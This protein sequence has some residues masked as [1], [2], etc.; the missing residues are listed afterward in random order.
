MGNVIQLR[1]LIRMACLNL[2]M[3][4]LTLR[5][6]DACDSTEMIFCEYATIRIQCLIQNL[7]SCCKMRINEQQLRGNDAEKV[8]I[9]VNN[10]FNNTY[11]ARTPDLSHVYFD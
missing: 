7:I 10:T 1:V 2:K 9:L 5:G 11:Q 8:A 6:T 4:H 3:S